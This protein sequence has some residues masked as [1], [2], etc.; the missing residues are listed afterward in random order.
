MSTSPAAKPH[1][2]VD[3]LA[4]FYSGIWLVFLIIPAQYLLDSP[5]MNTAQKALSIGALALFCIIYLASYGINHLVPAKTQTTRTLIWTLILLIPVIGYALVQGNSAIYLSTYLIAVW[6]FQTPPRLGLPVGVLIFGISL[7][8]MLFIFPDAFANGGFGFMIGAAFVL[9][10]GLITGLAERREE[11][12]HQLAQSQLTANIARDV[13]DILGH[14][15]TVI[16]LKA[17]LAQALLSSDPHKA[18]EE[19]KQ[20]SELSR[21]ALAEVRATV[22]RI[23]SSDLASELEA[24]RR[25]L[26]TVG[27][28]AVLPKPSQTSLAGANATL[29]SWVLREAVTNIIRHSGASKAWVAFDAH[30]IEITDDGGSQHIQEGNGLSGLRT[31]VEEAGGQLHITTGTHTRLLASMNGDTTPLIR[32]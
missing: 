9:V 7:F 10:M 19:M 30:R 29:Y 18:A 6:A 22:T 21:T 20:V 23:K 32:L 11:E 8:T 14:S 27:I 12:K 5:D 15:L 13:H 17:E 1:S 16:N 4:V 28:D 2:I 26:D 24:A 25:A 3:W 31:R